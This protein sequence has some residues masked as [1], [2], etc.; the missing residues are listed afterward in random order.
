MACS[1]DRPRP[2]RCRS[3]TASWT[4]SGEALAATGARI[5]TRFGTFF[6]GCGLTKALYLPKNA[7]TGYDDT[8][9]LASLKPHKNKLNLLSGL[10]AYIDDKPNIQHWTGNAAITTG[11]APANDTKFDAPN[12]RPDHCRRHR[13]RRAIPLHRSFLLRQ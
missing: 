12:H 2:W 13:P 11:I 1:G 8:P 10:R 3:W 9:Q 5:P 7:G 6:W 4:I